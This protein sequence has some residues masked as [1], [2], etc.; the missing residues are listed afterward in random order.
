MNMAVIPRREGDSEQRTVENVVPGV[1]YGPLQCGCIGQPSFYYSFLRSVNCLSR[2]FKAGV[3]IFGKQKDFFAS[4]FYT[5]I[6][7]TFLCAKDDIFKGFDLDED[8]I[9][10][11]ISHWD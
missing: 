5:A 3:W 10:Q 2:I 11:M 6:R 9:C 7:R 1:L 4:I 8:D